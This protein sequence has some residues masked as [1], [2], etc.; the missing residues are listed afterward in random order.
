MASNINYGL[1]LNGPGGLF[2][3]IIAST[4]VLFMNFFKELCF[5]SLVVPW[6]DQKYHS[7]LDRLSITVNL[8]DMLNH[9]ENDKT[10]VL[11]QYNGEKYL[12]IGCGN[13]PLMNCGGYLF[14]S[15]EEKE[16]YQMEHH[17]DGYYTINPVIEYNPS[18]IGFF[19][20][21]HF[22]SIPDGVFEEIE[23]EGFW[24]ELTEIAKSEFLRLLSD[25]GKV[26]VDGTHLF[27]KIDNKLI[28]MPNIILSDHVGI[29]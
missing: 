21:Q 3:K 8:S 4:Y 27:T 25:G 15:D 28:L 11:R 2:K 20:Y 10:I 26:I 18:I 12:M 22:L 16:K 1:N 7:I 29:V 13:K 19:S 6:N 9:F 23:T 5:E 14:E 17:H 24:L